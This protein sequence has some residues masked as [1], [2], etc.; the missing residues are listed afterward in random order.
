VLVNSP[1][2]TGRR[3]HPRPALPRCRSRSLYPSA[4]STVMKSPRLSQ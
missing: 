3:G 4:W 1:S 2:T